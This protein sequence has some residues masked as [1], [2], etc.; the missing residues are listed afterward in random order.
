MIAQVII[1]SNVKTLNKTFDYAV[2]KEL[3]KEVKQLNLG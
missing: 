1:D 3:E 2:P